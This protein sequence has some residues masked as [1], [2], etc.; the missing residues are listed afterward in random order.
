[1]RPEEETKK[2]KFKEAVLADI[3]ALL[4]DKESISI[5]HYCHLVWLRNRIIVKSK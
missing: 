1:M 2:R 3:E 5:L 4:A